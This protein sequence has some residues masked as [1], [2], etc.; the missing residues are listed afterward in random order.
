MAL[1]AVDQLERAVHR[2]P[3]RG[4]NLVLGEG[5]VS[6]DLADAFLLSGVGDGCRDLDGDM[7]EV[8]EGREKRLVGVVESGGLQDVKA[9]RGRLASLEKGRRTILASAATP[10]V[11]IFSVKKEARDTITLREMRSDWRRRKAEQERLTR[12]RAQGKAGRCCCSSGQSVSKE[13][14]TMKQYER[15]NSRLGDLVLL[16]SRRLDRRERRAGGHERQAV[17]PLVD[18]G[19]VGLRKFRRVCRTQIL[20]AQCRGEAKARNA[21]ERGKTIGRSTCLAISRTT[22]SSNAP[23]MVEQPIKIVGL[24]CLMT[25]SKSMRPSALRCQDET[26]DASRIKFSWPGRSVDECSVVRRPGRSTHLR[27]RRSQSRLA[28]RTRHL[29]LTRR[30]S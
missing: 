27:N 14:L 3:L 9:V 11:I 23:D 10:A 17:R 1:V 16:P 24:D 13:A 19:G 30:P 26:S 20:S 22:S 25:S 6:R 5:V 8:A 7:A 2:V 18:V 21:L 29:P 4:A 28:T 15:I 12:V